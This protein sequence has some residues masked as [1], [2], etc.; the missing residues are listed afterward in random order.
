MEQQLIALLALPGQAVGSSSLAGPRHL[1]RLLTALLQDGDPEPEVGIDGDGDVQCRWTV[2]GVEVTLVVDDGG[3]GWLWAHGADGS[4]V[5]YQ[6]WRRG[7]EPRA[8]LEAAAALLRPV[9]SVSLPA[10]AAVD[11]T[12]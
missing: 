3:S 1:F 6:E 9:T 4:E 10:T 8:A 11:L 7:E 12:R 2:G 5:A